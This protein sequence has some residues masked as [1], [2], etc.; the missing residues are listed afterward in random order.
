MLDVMHRRDSRVRPLLA[1]VLAAPWRLVPLRH[2]ELASFLTHLLGA[3]VA[4][5]GT[6]VLALHARTPTLALVSVVYGLSM[7]VMFSASAVY[8][9]LKETEDSALLWRRLDHLAI[10]FMI[11]GTYTPL[12]FAYLSGA[13]RH[14]ILGAQWGL[15]LLGLLFKLVWLRSPRYLTTAVYLVMGWMAVIPMRQMLLTLDPTTTV[16]LFAGGGAYTAGAFVYASKRPD[17]A[18]GLFG[19]HE[20]FHVLV[21]AGAALHFAAVLRAVG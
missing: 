17:P 1:A 21:L 4:V 15:V 13:W 5:A 10:F 6:V 14:G 16:L 9:A 8:H 19:F 20:V 2:E 7:T 18:P 3:V 12:C 11:A